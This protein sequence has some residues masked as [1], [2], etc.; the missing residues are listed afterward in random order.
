MHEEKRRDA[1]TAALCFF[2][3]DGKEKGFGLYAQLSFQKNLPVF[4]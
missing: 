1:L 4:C 3:R 2:Y